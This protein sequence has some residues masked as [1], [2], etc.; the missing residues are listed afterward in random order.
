MGGGTILN[1]GMYPIQFCQ[2]V[3]QQEPQSIRVL[4]SRLNDDG[5]D[6]ELSVE[7]GYGEDRIAKIRQSFLV[8]QSNRAKIVGTDGELKVNAAYMFEKVKLN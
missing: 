8:L 2:W 1:I 7:I 4:S 5:I 3:F 6:V